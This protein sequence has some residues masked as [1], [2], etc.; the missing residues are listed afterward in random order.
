M[1]Y[2]VDVW[3][4]VDMPTVSELRLTD[5]KKILSEVERGD[6]TELKA[7]G[8]RPPEVFTSRAR[9]GK[10]EIWGVIVRPSNFDPL[11]KYPVIENIY[12]GPRIVCPEKFHALESNAVLAELGFIVVQVDGM[13]TANRSKAFHDVAWK[14][15]NAGFPTGSV[16]QG[17][18]CKISLLRHQQGRV[19]GTSGQN[20]LADCYSIPSSTRYALQRAAVTTIG[21][22]LVERAMDG[23]ASRTRI[24]CCVRC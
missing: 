20:S 21:Q 9:D 5:G 13:G 12:A 2:Y 18:G 23:M 22:A 14:N 15:L 19:Y 16:A 3:S 6:I 10:T 8:W 4:R 24:R 17:C 7:A 11:K 1:K